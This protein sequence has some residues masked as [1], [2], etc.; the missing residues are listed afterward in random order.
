ME[1]L[2]PWALDIQVRSSIVTNLA[3]QLTPSYL[4]LQ[5]L[6]KVTST[7]SSIATITDQAKDKTRFIHQASDQLLQ[8]HQSLIVANEV[9]SKTLGYFEDLHILKKKLANLTPATNLTGILIRLDEIVAFL[10]EKQ[11]IY[12][13]APSS[14]ELA[15]QL[16]SECLIAIKDVIVKSIESAKLAVTP[17]N[18]LSPGDTIYTLFYGQFSSECKKLKN[19]TILLEERSANDLLFE[20]Q[21]AYLSA[22]ESLL[23]PVLSVAIEEMSSSGQPCAFVKNCCHMFSNVTRDEERLYLQFFTSTGIKFNSFLQAISTKLYNALRPIVIRLNH[24]ESLSQV[25][26]IL[27]EQMVNLLPLGMALERLL[28]DAKERLVYRAAIYT[29]ENIKMYNPS[30]GD[31][32]YPEKLFMMKQIAEETLKSSESTAANSTGGPIRPVSSLSDA[33]FAYE[34]TSSVHLVASSP[35][36]VHGMWYPSVR[37]AILCLSRLYNCLDRPTFQQASQ[38]VVSACLFSL[39]KATSGIETKTSSKLDSLLFLI[40]HLLIVREQI[41]P[42][43]IECVVREFN[44]DQFSSSSSL[45]KLLFED[46]VVDHVFDAKKILDSK[47]RATCNEFVKVAVGMIHSDSSTGETKVRESMSLYL[48]NVDTEAI[49]WKLVVSTRAKQQSAQQQQQQ[50]PRQQVP[51]Q[52]LPLQQQQH[53]QQQQQQQQHQPQSQPEQEEQ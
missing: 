35:A 17:G 22:R 52:Q 2:A 4:L 26:L 5:Q 24:F 44:L 45:V 39:E 36:D 11:F 28:G 19:L 48:A 34:S 8:E 9:I 53:H 25:C 16:H 38:E 14:L 21:E 37:R 47:I 15:V 49:L 12:K 31:L 30:P 46:P 51:Q 6:D 43:H 42:F 29:E 41:A 40:K 7:F 3:P 33:S 13:D 10:S 50:N 1:H 20:C 18:D 23:S 32:A 27:K